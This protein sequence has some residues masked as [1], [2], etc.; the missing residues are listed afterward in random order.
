MDCREVKIRVN[1]ARFGRE[2]GAAS[3]KVTVVIQNL[4]VFFILLQIFF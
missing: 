4:C 1:L 2:E 3:E